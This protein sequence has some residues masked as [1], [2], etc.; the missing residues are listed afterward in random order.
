MHR[1]TPYILSEYDLL[2]YT[3]F[4]KIHCIT[5]N[6][7]LNITSTYIDFHFF[8]IVSANDYYD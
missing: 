4:L 8:K 2:E 7:A 1:R 3:S 5:L 6:S